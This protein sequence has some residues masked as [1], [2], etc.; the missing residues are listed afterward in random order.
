M[1]LALAREVDVLVRG[2]KDAEKAT[3][4]ARTNDDAEL[5]LSDVM[6]M[7]T[8]PFIFVLIRLGSTISL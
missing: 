2:A 6:G 8:D 3:L 7:S 4:L 1:S 5:A